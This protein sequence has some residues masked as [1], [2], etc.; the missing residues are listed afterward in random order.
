MIVFIHNNNLYKIIP[1]NLLDNNK[2][3]KKN[4]LK[5]KKIKEKKLSTILLIQR[6]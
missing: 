2:D 6:N 5:S 3:K 4:L 1:F